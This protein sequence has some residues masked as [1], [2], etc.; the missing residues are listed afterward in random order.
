MRNIHPYS[1]LLALV[2][3]F[4]PASSQAQLSSWMYKAPITVTEQAGISHAPYQ[5]L[6]E[7]NTQALVNAGKMQSSGADIRFGDDCGFTTYPHWIYDYM[8]TDSTLIWVM[9]DSLPANDSVTVYMYYGNSGAAQASDFNATFPNAV[10]SGGSSVTLTGTQNIGW[11]EIQTG[12]T[13]FIGSGSLLDITAR[14]VD[15]KGYVMGE[16]RGYQSATGPVAGAGPGGGGTST[17]AGSG[18]GGY[19]GTGGGGGFDSGDTPGAGG[20]T[21]GTN[22]L[23]DVDM[24]SAGGSSDNTLGGSGGGGLRIYSEYLL[25]QGPVNLDGAEGQQPGG[26]RG[27]GGG[28][29]GGALLIGE[30]VVLTNV[31]SAKGGNSS[32]GTST[33]NDDGGG[34]GGGRIKVHY[35]SVLFN[36]G[37]TVVTGGSGGVNGSAGTGAPGSAGTSYIGNVPFNPATYSLGSETLNVSAPALT[38]S[39]SDA[40]TTI[41]PNEP[42]TMTAASGFSQYTFY[43]NGSPVQSG[44][45]NSYASSN[46]SNGDVLGV[47]ADTLS[48]SQYLEVTIGVIAVPVLTV[49]ASDTTGCAGDSILLV[50]SGNFG[51]YHWDPGNVYNDSTWVT[52]GGDYHIVATDSNGCV[53]YDT[54]HIE[55]TQVQLEINGSTSGCEGDTLLIDAGSGHT[56]Y[57]WSSGGT[58]QTENFTSSGLIWVEV[59]DSSGCS[60]RDSLTLTLHPAPVPVI[61]NNGGTLETGAGYSSYQWMLGG[62]AIGGATTNTY[63]PLGSGVY[64]VEVTD[65][66]GCTGVSD[67][68]IITIG[69]DGG[70]ASDAVRIWPNPAKESLQLSIVTATAG[71]RQVEIIDLTGRVLLRREIRIFQGETRSELSLDG[72]SAGAYLLRIGN[73]TVR[74]VKQ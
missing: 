70:F 37:S 68:T 12:D 66:N 11:M 73:R 28:S 38:V 19:G 35:G 16:G 54:I 6:I 50:G 24:G 10:I 5:A 17:N 27:G 34:G 60:V 57:L 47:A 33:A 13:L 42:F 74:F 58:G 69:I 26:S 56:S 61:T 18:G 25:V 53:S 72:L 59:T 52:V 4:A 51:S 30:Q 7:V 48:C 67:T 43:V 2:F 64:S 15:I 36:F 22:N 41:C 23:S 49:T 40:D 45:S 1:A 39:L 55:L 62:S 8:N 20:I 21:Y 44:T 3:L 46:Y 63:T 31:I 71:E 14:Y 29:G 32:V 9:L 65:S